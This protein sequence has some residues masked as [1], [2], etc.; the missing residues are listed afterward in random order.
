M[1]SSKRVNRLRAVALGV[2]MVGIVAGFILGAMFPS[3]VVETTT[4]LVKRKYT[5][6]TTS[7][8]SG[9]TAF[10]WLFFLLILG[11]SVVASAVLYGAAE[12]AGSSRR[13]RSGRSDRHEFGDEI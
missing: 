12:I 2:L 1:S 11:P 7:S 10:N 8:D 4:G 13:S 5:V 6:Y 3:Q 9:E